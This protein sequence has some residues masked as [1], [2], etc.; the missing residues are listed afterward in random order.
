VKIVFLSKMKRLRSNEADDAMIPT[1]MLKSGECGVRFDVPP[2]ATTTDVWQKMI[3]AFRLHF[4][5]EYM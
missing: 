3:D 5:D 2:A 1:K 4:S